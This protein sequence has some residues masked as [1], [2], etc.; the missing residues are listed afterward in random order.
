MARLDPERGTDTPV[1]VMEYRTPPA[2]RPSKRQ[3]GWSIAFWLLMTVTA[4]TV[5]VTL[6]T[7]AAAWFG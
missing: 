3:V 1:P 4:L 7:L 6:V 2:D 5:V